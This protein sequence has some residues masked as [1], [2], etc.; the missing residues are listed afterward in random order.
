MDVNCVTSPGSGPSQE[1][2]SGKAE[3]QNDWRHEVGPILRTEYDVPP[4]EC[5]IEPWNQSSG[6]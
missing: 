1:V 4:S 3:A 2:Y 6:C 5:V